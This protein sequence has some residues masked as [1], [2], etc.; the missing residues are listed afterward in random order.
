MKDTRFILIDDDP[1][2]NMICR[3]TVQKV[4]G[5]TDVVSFTNAEEA[6]KYI[7]SEFSRSGLKHAKL[8]LDINMPIMTGWEFLEQFDKFDQQ[9]K[10]YIAIYILSSSLDQQD[11]ERSQSNKNVR[12]HFQ[13]PLTH[14]ALALLAE[15]VTT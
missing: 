7:S 14:E 4:F 8:L 2:S 1:V 12:M 5:I 15:C 10:S 11:K 3:I 9:I 13:K 6:L